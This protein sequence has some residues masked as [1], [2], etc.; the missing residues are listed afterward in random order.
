LDRTD[1][2][3]HYEPGNCRW[4]THREQIENSRVS[5][6]VEIRGVNYPSIRAAADALGI[7]EDTLGDRLR[8]GADPLIATQNWRKVTVNGVEYPSIKAASIELGIPY[9]TLWRA[10]A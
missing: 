3:G 6:P 5:K 2:D 10:V 8:R 4:I 7:N 1:N 9:A